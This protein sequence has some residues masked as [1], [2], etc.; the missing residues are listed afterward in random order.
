MKTTN[1]RKLSIAVIGLGKMGLLHACLLNFMPNVRLSVICDK[2]WLMRAIAKRTLGGPL[3]TDN[4]DELLKLDLDAI[5]VLTPIPSHYAIIKEIYAKNIARNVFVEKTLASN[6]A[7]SETLCKLSEDQDGINMVGYMKRFAVTFNKAK[8]LLGKQTIG[9][10]L[11]FDAYA[12]SSDFANV[13][14]DSAISGARGGALEDLGS[15]VV[16]LA[17]WFFGDLTVNFARLESRIAHGSEDSV[18][19]EVT[20]LNGLEGKFDVSWCKN[21]YRMPE[22]GLIIRGSKG[23]LIVK[24]DEMML[25]LNDAQ[26]IKWY[27]HDLDDSVGFLLGGSEY[28]REDEHFVKSMMSGDTPEP[29]FRTAMKVDLLIDKVRCQA[30]E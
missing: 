2:S 5:Y 18:Y 9:K 1:D 22:S 14:D 7:Q 20:G 12:F 28:F 27:R 10:L 25:E 15:H 24:D 17:L 23:V 11:S 16:D 3:L 30:N 29:N 8:E 21:G 13:K 26:P 6:Y 4:L 19:F